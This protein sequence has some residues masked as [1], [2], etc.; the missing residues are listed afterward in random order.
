MAV[1][2]VWKHNKSQRWIIGFRRQF[3]TSAVCT[4]AQSLASHESPFLSSLRDSYGDRLNECGGGSGKAW[5]L[6]TLSAR[7]PTG[8]VLTVQPLSSHESSR[9]PA[10]HHFQVLPLHPNIQMS[11]GHPSFSNTLCIRPA[12]PS[13][14]YLSHECGGVGSTLIWSSSLRVNSETGTEPFTLKTV[15]SAERISW[16]LWTHLRLGAAMKGNEATALKWHT[17]YCIYF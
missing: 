4:R 15:L 10:E 12:N 14:K 5:A 2:L 11:A 8:P 13:E 1:Q 7:A 6:P 9:E 17:R 16:R 3:H